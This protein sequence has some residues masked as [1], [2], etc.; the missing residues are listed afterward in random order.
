LALPVV[1][2]EMNVGMKNVEMEVRMEEDFT[3]DF[4]AMVT[5]EEEVSSHMEHALIVEPQTIISV[6]VQIFYNAH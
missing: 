6:N 2:K 3:E 4:M 5:A 1:P